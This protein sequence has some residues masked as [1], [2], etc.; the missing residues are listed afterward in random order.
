MRKVVGLFVGFTLIAV[1][2]GSALAQGPG[3]GMMGGDGPHMRGQMGQVDG[4]RGTMQPMMEQ[5]MQTCLQMMQQMTEAM[6]QTAPEPKPP[7]QEK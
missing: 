2:L 4:M 7:T 3:Q 6:G 5:M 1:L